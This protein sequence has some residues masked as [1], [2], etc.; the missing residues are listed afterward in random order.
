[1]AD[2][3]DWD[4]FNTAEHQQAQRTCTHLFHCAVDGTTRKAVSDLLAYART[5]NDGNAIVMR[6]A[7]LSGPCCL[8]PAETPG[9]PVAEQ[10]VKEDTPC[11]PAGETPST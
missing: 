1:V 3:I 5:V 6:V 2:D 10:N 8:P 11:P 7:Q 4:R 9:Q